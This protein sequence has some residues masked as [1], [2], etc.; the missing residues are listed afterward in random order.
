MSKKAIAA[1]VIVVLV[2]TLVS[3]FLLAGTIVKFNKESEENQKVTLCKDSVQF[4]AATTLSVAD[5]EEIKLFPPLCQ[6]IDKKVSGDQAKVQKAI[7]DSM[8]TCWQMFGEGR[9]KKNIFDTISSFGGDASCFIC[10]TILVDP[11][12]KFKENDL[13]KPADFQ[14]YLLNTPYRSYTPPD[15]PKGT[16]KQIES[17]H[18]Y[19]QSGNGPGY[20]YGFL[21]DQGI[22]PGRAYAVMYKA[23][24]TD[25][26]ATGA[27]LG[28][29]AGTF[30]VGS[31]FT[32]NILGAIAGAAVAGKTLVEGIKLIITIQ[33]NIDGI[34][35][36]DI[37]DPDLRTA[38][39]EGEDHCS[40]V[41]DLAGG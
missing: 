38:F 35:L 13:V 14:T 6:T 36:V 29:A 17:Y 21:T 24:H 19:I 20:V 11:S 4:R 15:S 32:G 26:G 23:K 8:A 16:P 5:V 22:Q 25:L 28:V 34:Y 31:V 33:T 10:Y 41:G 1:G 7:A 27:L 12:T 39:F 40:Y 2:V 37:S 9:F 30:A 3:F 18:Q